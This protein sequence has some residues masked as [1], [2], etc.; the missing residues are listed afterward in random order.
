MAT[1]L[2]GEPLA[3]YTSF[4]VGGSAETV[5]FC[6]TSNDFKETLQKASNPWILGYGSNVVISDLGLPGETIIFNGGSISRDDSIIIVDAGVWWDDLVNF[7]I[8]SELWGFECMSGIPG[9]VGAAVVGN[10][11][12]YGQAVADTLEWVEVYDKSTG[13]VTKKQAATLSLS[14]RSSNVKPSEVILRAAFKLSTRQTKQ[15][16]YASALSIAEKYGYDTTTLEG[17]RSTILKARQEAHSLYDPA[18]G[19]FNKTAGSFFK[20]PIVDKNTATELARYDESG[21]TIEQILQQNQVHTGDSY[22]ASAAH[23]LLACGFRR[24][25][26]WGDVGLNK[27]HILK[28]ENLGQ[29]KAQDIFE[30]VKVIQDGVKEKLEITLETEVRFMGEFQ[31]KMYGQ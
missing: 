23:I 3:D 7:A 15:L 21:K 31:G 6:E 9:S 16:V 5:Y 4:G 11:A 14:Y 8:E 18:M 17:V 19:I 26:R 29:A 28:I 25:Q 22:R 27:Q 10:I 13:V 12:A 1:T 30:V 2:H 20:N 24:G